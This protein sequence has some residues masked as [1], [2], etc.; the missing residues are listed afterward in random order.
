MEPETIKQELKNANSVDE[1]QDVIDKYKIS[2][3][4]NQVAGTRK[5]RR[6]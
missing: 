4:S 6:P 1:V 5:K 2:F 3:S